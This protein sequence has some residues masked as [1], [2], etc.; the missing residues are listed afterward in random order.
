M[1][2]VDSKNGLS[3]T[4]AA[5]RLEEHG[6]NELEDEEETSIWEKIRESFEDLLARILL[7]AATISFL[8]AFFSDQEEGIG[9]Y[10]EPFVILL[11]LVIN[12]VVAI[13]QDMDAESALD[14][15]KKMQ[16]CQCKVLRNGTWQNMNSE[17]LVP[18]DI[19]KIVTGS[20]IPADMRLI[21]MESMS[22][23]VEEAPLTG[24]SVSVNKQVE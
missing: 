18:G 15:L 7:L 8:I 20:N 23:Q 13:Y 21:E 10:V 4:E 5:K 22:L 1:F 12:A 24:E 3:N 2:K 9:A 16:A 6:P 17:E 11:I 14:A 19:V